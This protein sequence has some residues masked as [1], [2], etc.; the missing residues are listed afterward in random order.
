VPPEGHA[1]LG[2][3]D[4]VLLVEQVDVVSQHRLGDVGHEV[5]EQ[6][7]PHRPAGPVSVDEVATAPVTEVE[8]VDAEAGHLCVAFDHETPAFAA[9]ALEHGRSECAFDDEPAFVKE[10]AH[11]RGG[12]LWDR[13]RH[14]RSPLLLGFL[15]EPAF[16]TCRSSRR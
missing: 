1:A 5:G 3:L 7:L 6:E 15:A 2:G 14:F 10:P 16:S 11:V 9:K 12:D 8:R 4:D 13:G